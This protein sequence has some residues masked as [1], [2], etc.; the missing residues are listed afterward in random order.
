MART[1]ARPVARE[2]AA[3][4]NP[5]VKEEQKSWAAR[6]LPGKGG[7]IKPFSAFF[8]WASWGSQKSSRTS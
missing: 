6:Q 7:E 2:M 1:A 3:R 8:T 5:G 4:P